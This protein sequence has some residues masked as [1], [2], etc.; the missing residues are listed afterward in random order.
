MTIAAPRP[1]VE[2]G[3]IFRQTFAVLG[4]NPV[5]FLIIA[6]LFIGIPNALFGF[7]WPQT[8]GAALPTAATWER[9]AALVVIA[10]ASGAIMQA[11][12]IH[13]AVADMNGRKSSLA[14]CLT[15]GLAQALPVAAIGLLL[16][17]AI[18]AGF[19]LLIIPGIIIS[20]AFSVA[21]AAQV[22]E[23]T[24]IIG[25]FQRS[26]VLTRNHRGVIFGVNFVIGLI[27]IV[28]SGVMGAIVGGL[29]GAVAPTQVLLL[30]NVL[31]TPVTSAVTGT[32]SASSVA[33]IY[34]ELRRVKEGV[35]TEQL[36]ALF[37]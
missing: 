8:A 4:R 26:A 22:V 32:I 3:Q 29:I 35:G 16:G 11:A 15:A 34:F 7:L 37:D 36:A 17:L 30:V 14:E 19:I 28:A 12:I 27:I 20:L 1:Q 18:I 10:S 21:V 13:G 33:A 31:V 23:N 9:L 5:N 6:L 25:A 2:F 24:G